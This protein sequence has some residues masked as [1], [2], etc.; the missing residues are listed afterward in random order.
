MTQKC[1]SLPVEKAREVRDALASIIDS[2]SAM[3][4]AVCFYFL[5]S[6]PVNAVTPTFAITSLQVQNGNAIV[7]WQGGGATNQLQRKNSL[8]GPWVN[9]GQP[10]TASSATDPIVGPTAFYRIMAVGNVGG[11]DNLP[12][13]VNL[14][15]PS[16]ASTVSG[17]IA[18]TATANDNSGGAGVA[19]VEFYRDNSVLLGA[20]TT[21]PYT[22]NLDTTTLANN[23]HNFYAKAYDAAGNSAASATATVTINNNTAASG[24]AQWVRNMTSGYRLLPAAVVA[25]HTNNVIAVGTFMDAAGASSDFGG[26]P[27]ANA[28]GWTGFI[29]KYSAQ[30]AFVWVKALAGGVSSVAV[31]GQN[32]I[33]ATGYFQ[34]S[35]DFGGVTLTSTLNPLGAYSSDIFIVKY[36]PSGGLL[37]AKKFGGNGN[38]T[39]T[40]VAVDASGNVFMAAQFSS[41]SIDLGTGLLN[42]LGDF[43]MALVKLSG[44][45]G[46]TMWAK[47]WGSIGYDIPNG[48]AV[49]GSG[50]VLLTG[51]AAGSINLGGGSIGIGGG[52]VSKYSGTDGTHRWS[53]ALGGTAGFGIAADPVTS[54]VFVTGSSGG[55]FLNAYDSAGNPLWSKVNGGSGDEGRAIT[56]DASGNVA[57]TGHSSQMLDFGDGIYRGGGYLFVANYTTAGGFRWAKRAN[58]NTGT[59]IAFDSLGHVLATGNFGGSLALTVD[60]G[61]VSASVG[62]GVTDGFVVEYT[63]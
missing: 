2:T 29:A 43:D 49:D 46:A 63:K 16:V 41:V 12:P 17:T 54:K 18:L 13:T 52:V 15:S 25:D 8:T 1:S 38:D 36:S 23:S 62:M 31:D 28:A 33:F 10:T 24:Q 22:Y 56:V 57:I 45:T 9:V 42:S 37:W 47:T 7:R 61:G 14:V 5:A 40:A 35:V 58:T 55:F 20:T 26:G 34:G 44:A 39:G 27:M 60:F 51:S 21:A 53:K 30:N 48:V 32:N 3:L 50:D 6:A 19:R 11:A 4:L 59:G